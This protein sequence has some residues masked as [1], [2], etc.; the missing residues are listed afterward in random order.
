ME[1]RQVQYFV[2]VADCGQVTRAAQRLHIAQ[3]AVSQQIRHLERELGVALFERT[4]HGMVFTEAGAVFAVRARRILRELALA[5]QEVKS[6]VNGFPTQRVALG[7]IHSLDDSVVPQMLTA[8]HAQ[9]PDIRVSVREDIGDRLLTSLERGELE[10][11]ICH[12][13]TDD[14]RPGVVTERLFLQELVLAVP[15]AHPVAGRADVLLSELHDQLFVLPPVGSGL[16]HVIDRAMAGASLVP[17]VA[18]ETSAF[19][20][21]RAM[22]EQGVGIAFIPGQLLEHAGPAIQVARP[23]PRMTRTISLARTN[24]QELGSG[25]EI[26]MTF[27]RAHF[28]GLDVGDVH[29][30]TDASHVRR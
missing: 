21:M 16:R 27:A 12:V 25:A 26:F 28:R 10:V 20:T 5:E 1:L 9:R 23:E 6:L 22:V 29:E 19:Q 8:F 13:D 30:T 11:V 15:P 14:H 4:S 24:D 3:P 7:A 18:A 2:E 17:K